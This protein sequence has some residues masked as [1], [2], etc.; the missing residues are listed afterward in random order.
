MTPLAYDGP[1]AL[2][3]ANAFS[4][5]EL[6]PYLACGIA[7][8][9]IAY[10]LG[11]V[12]MHRR[13]D[14]W[15]WLRT[16]SFLVGGI[17]SIVLATMSALGAYDD[18]LFT[19]HMIQHMILSMVAPVFLALGAPVT[20]ALRT[21]RSAPR[22]ALLGVLH[23]RVARFF[24][25]TPI[26]WAH[27]VLLPFVL[28]HTQWYAATLRPQRA[29]RAAALPDPGRRLPVLLAAAGAGSRCPA[30]SPTPPGCW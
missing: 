16:V 30:G 5:W 17:G 3:V 22:K 23:S 15:P 11:V 25:W 21:F 9:A 4:Q 29:A 6:D 8:V 19:D 24:T 2:S 7:V 28:Y 12:Q 20:L 26:A 14:G 27:F 10:A 13:G 1:P 18:V